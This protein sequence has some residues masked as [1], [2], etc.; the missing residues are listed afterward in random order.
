METKF[1]ACRICRHICSCFNPRLAH[2]Q[3]RKNSFLHFLL[4]KSWNK[5]GLRWICTIGLISRWAIF[6]KPF[7]ENHLFWKQSSLF[8]C[9][10]SKISHKDGFNLYSWSTN[11]WILC[12]L[13]L[14]SVLCYWDQK[15][16][17]PTLISPI[18]HIDGR[19]SS[20]GRR[21]DVGLSGNFILGK[22]GAPRKR[23]TENPTSLADH[24]QPYK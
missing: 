14:H 9:V 7:Y 3:S 22:L 13:I 24:E 16:I 2:Q 23:K 4:A 5:S 19:A 12:Y 17:N 8:R 21:S 15:R 20:F 18:T 6:L 11:L 1:S 10:W